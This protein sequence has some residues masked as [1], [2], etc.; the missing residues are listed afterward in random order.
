MSKPR[1][2]PLFRIIG[3]PPYRFGKNEKDE[4]VRYPSGVERPKNYE[5]DCK[6]VPR[7]CP[8]VTCENNTYFS[9]IT[10]TRVLVS[11][12]GLDP[13]QV[14]AE[15]SCIEDIVRSGPLGVREIG[16]IIG[17]TWQR[18]SQIEIAGLEKLKEK[19]KCQKT[20]LE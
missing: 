13:D 5:R 2:M 12:P 11:R 19:L 18:V 3:Q 6:D 14:P 9:E 16:E 17:N 8:F 7:P 1:A 20:K 10:E 15:T 4:W